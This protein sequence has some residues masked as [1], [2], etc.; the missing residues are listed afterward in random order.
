MEKT[1]TNV[2]KICE[3][4][5]R[6]MQDL[7]IEVSKGL[8]GDT[9]IHELGEVVDMVKDLAEAEEKCWKA[10]YYKHVIEEMKKYDET[11]PRYGEHN[12][13]PE[14]M[15]W[16]YN[17][18][19]YSSGRYAP[20]GRGHISGYHDDMMMGME[21]DYFL[22]GIDSD[23]YRKGGHYGHRSSGYT[24]N[25]MYGKAYHDFQNARRHYTESKSPEDKKMMDAHIMEHVDNFVDTTRDILKAADRP[26]QKQMKADLK[27]L[28]AD[29]P[30]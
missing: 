24:P 26:L 12:Y 11:T 4:K 3:V 30:D 14:M 6:I 18:R 10:C 13:A 28:I 25:T 5:D 17:T 9:N 29:I 23:G 19:R 2:S 7:C 27:A 21:E 20:A 1:K 16:G 22:D 8:Y 15:P